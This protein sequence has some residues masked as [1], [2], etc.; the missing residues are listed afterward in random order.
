MSNN[1]SMMRSDAAK[2]LVNKKILA[3]RE[4]TAAKNDPI[5]KMDPPKQSATQPLTIKESPTVKSKPLEGKIDPAN[6]DFDALMKELD[7]IIEDRLTTNKDVDD[8]FLKNVRR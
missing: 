3:D 1:E 7:L 4:K 8:Y 6:T 5:N 2:P